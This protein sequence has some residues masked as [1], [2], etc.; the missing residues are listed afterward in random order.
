[1]SSDQISCLLNSK[2]LYIAAVGT[3][4]S[5]ISAARKDQTANYPFQIYL[6]F[7]YRAQ[8]YFQSLWIFFSNCAARAMHLFFTIFKFNPIP[9]PTN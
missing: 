5:Q 4:W 7:L 6:F 9:R 2:T 1:M 3:A 8:M